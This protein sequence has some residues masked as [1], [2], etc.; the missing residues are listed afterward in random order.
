MSTAYPNKMIDLRTLFQQAI[1]AT[2]THPNDRENHASQGTKLRKKRG[3]NGAGERN[4]TPDRLI[5][6]QL[7]YL[8]SYASQIHAFE[9][10][11]I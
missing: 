3:W 10:V 4:R 5:T 1:Q 8:L 7:L 9:P 6:N 11:Y 2:D